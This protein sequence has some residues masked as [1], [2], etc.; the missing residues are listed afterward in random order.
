MQAKFNHRS[1]RVWS[2][3]WH[4][5]ILAAALLTAAVVLLALFRHRSSGSPQQG[6]QAS[7]SDYVDATV[8]A[9][10]HQ[11]IAETYR[12]T[13]MGRSFFLP[14]AGKVVEDYAHANTVFHQPSGLRY[15]MVERDGEFFERRSEVGFDG[16]ETN[17]MEER[18][19][20]VIG[21]GNHSRSYLHRA[22]DGQLIELPVSWYSEG[23]GYWAMSPGYDWKGQKD[24]RRAITGECMFCHNGYPESDAGIERSIFPQKLP[25]GIDCQRCH[26]PGRAHVEAAMSGHASPELVRSTIVNPGRLDRERQLEVCMECHLKTSFHEPNEERAFDRAV[27]SY[28]PGQ[29]LKDFKLYFEPVGHEND[30]NFEIDHAAYRLRKSACFRNSQMTCLTCHDPHDIPRGQEAVKHYTEVCLSCHQGVAHTVALPPTSTCLTCHMPKRRTNDA[31]HVVMT[32]HFIRRTQP[33]R[34]LLAPIAETIAPE[35]SFTKVA[36]YYPAKAPATP[37]AEISMAEAQVS[38][39]GIPRLQAL[40]ERYRPNSPEPYLALADAYDREGNNEEV[41]RWSRRALAQRENFRTAVVM[42]APALFALH[43][44]AEATKVLEEA[45][46]QYP[47]DD[48]LLSDLGNAYLRQGEMAQA[49]AALKRAFEANPDRSE[50]H[51]LLGVVSVKQGDSAAGEHEFREALRCQPNFPEARDNLGSLL[52]VEHNYTEAAFQFEKAIE[53]DGGFA[54]AH[55]HLG[56][57]LVLMDQLPRAVSELREAAQLE[58]DDPEVHEDLADVLAATGHTAEAIPEY[59]RV[60]ALRPDQSQAH[61][62]SGMAMLSQHRVTEARVHL[63]AAANSS[64]PEIAQAARRLLAQF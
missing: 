16:K 46:K 21:S 49:S 8:C 62:G 6:A 39:N 50:T 54:E 45:V 48:L 14:T 58:P 10:C 59:E 12:K 2:R 37:E 31:V 7:Q 51:N 57:L 55:H 33:Q 29:P 23:S 3:V 26:G 47:G 52:A 56:R 35:G 32:D 20:Y 28:R 36:L 61:L 64:D 22:P 30:D 24:F 18:I 4:G 40:L 44:D 5:A 60:L 42:L 1:R 11:D 38:D 27:F 13:G 9:N 17:A 41:A 63:E 25:Q 19:D 43:Q 15:T 34:N 53:A